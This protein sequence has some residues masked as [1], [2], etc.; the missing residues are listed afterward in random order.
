VN[1]VVALSGGKDSTALA[2]RLAEIE[3]RDYTYLCT[4]TGDELPE[5]VAHWARLEELLGKPIVRLTNGTLDSWIEE[6]GALPNWR[7]RW[8]TRLLKIE[9]CITYVKQ[10][11]PATLY[12]GLRADEDERVGL[13]GDFATYRYPLREWEWGVE[14]VWA[15]L[16]ERGIKIPRRTDCARCYGQ[17][18]IEWKRLWQDYPEI[19]ASAEA[20]E[21]KVR[22][23]FRSPGRDTWPASL[24]GL[25]GEFERG[26][27]VRGERADE[28]D[29]GQSCRVC[30]L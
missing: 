5:M 26:R 14:E 30:R 11:Q 9:P 13:Y 28:D 3:P 8:C 25:R 18:L 16:N 29:D 27:K 1:H 15:Y 4:P 6:F 24:E 19:Y 12:V 21:K 7:Q 23:T 2:L 20:Q 22:A 17:R 10:H